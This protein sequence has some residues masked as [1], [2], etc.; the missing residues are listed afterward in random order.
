MNLTPSG[1]QLFGSEARNLLFKPRS[2]KFE[3]HSKQSCIS[4]PEFLND[5]FFYEI[6]VLYENTFVFREIHVEWP[7]LKVFN[8]LANFGSQNLFL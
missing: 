5:M 4:F 6:L 8:H 2:C 7:L 3:R 1:L